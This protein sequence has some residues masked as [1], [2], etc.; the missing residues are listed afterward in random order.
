ME[1]KKCKNNKK[2]ACFKGYASSHNV[3]IFNSFNPE[4]QLKVT[5]SAIKSKVIELLGS[6]E[7]FLICDISFS[8]QK[9]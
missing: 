5:E 9:R 4:L 7:G 2:S 1:R 6:I 3:E 8:I